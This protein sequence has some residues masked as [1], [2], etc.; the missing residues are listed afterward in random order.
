[1]MP[2]DKVIQSTIAFNIQKNMLVYGGIAIII[3]DTI[4]EGAIYLRTSTTDN[5]CTMLYPFSTFPGKKTFF[6]FFRYHLHPTIQVNF[7]LSFLYLPNYSPL[8]IL[9]LLK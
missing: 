8:I 9:R 7:F 2:N 5:P 6:P 3:I 1:M 4:N